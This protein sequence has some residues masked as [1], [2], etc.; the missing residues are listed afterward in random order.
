[1]T[2][3]DRAADALPAL[4]TVPVKTALMEY[5]PM[6][7]ISLMEAV[8]AEV[9][10]AVP[11]TADP[12]QRAAAA[13]LKVTSPEETGK[14]PAM[15]VTASVTGE[16]LVTVPGDT[17]KTDTV[18]AGAACAIGTKRKAIAANGKLLTVPARILRGETRRKE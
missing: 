7:M 11:N 10:C 14:L 18:L 9:N 3:N 5:E 16:P 17:P 15:T 13:S 8:P 4:V 1:V 2:L 12:S 6:P